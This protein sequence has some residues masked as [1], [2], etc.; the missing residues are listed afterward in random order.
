M[1]KKI[2]IGTKDNQTAYNIISQYVNSNDITFTNGNIEI[3]NNDDKI[4]QYN[5]I[6]VEHG[7]AVNKLYNKSQSLEEYFIEKVG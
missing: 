3:K 4:C 7:I 2:I 6:L 1:R 5:K